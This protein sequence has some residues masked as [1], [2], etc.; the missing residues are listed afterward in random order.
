MSS[1]TRSVSLGAAGRVLTPDEQLAA[2]LVSDELRAL[3][4]RHGWRLTDAVAG[5]TTSA[6]CLG[7]W[8][9]D[10]LAGSAYISLP[11]AGVLTAW[12]EGSPLGAFLVDAVV[13]AMSRQFP[14]PVVVPGVGSFGGASAYQRLRKRSVRENAVYYGLHNLERL[15]SFECSVC[16]CRSVDVCHSIPRAWGGNLTAGNLT[17]D[18]SACNRRQSSMPGLATIE[19]LKFYSLLLDVSPAAMGRW[20]S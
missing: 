13:S 11:V 19:A 17:L 6:E 4:S 9:L 18:C 8:S 7:S 5:I 15:R 1:R 10:A 2:G 12:G 3:C 20:V 16:Y 14:S